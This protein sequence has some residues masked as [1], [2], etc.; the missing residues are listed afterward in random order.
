MSTVEA[1]PYQQFVRRK[2]F[3][4]KKRRQQVVLSRFEAGV[5]RLQAAIT[6][7]VS[8]GRKYVNLRELQLAY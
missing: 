7:A 5:P 1:T 8:E 3:A 4:I 2:V 6:K